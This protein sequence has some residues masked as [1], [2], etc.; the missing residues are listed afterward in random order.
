MGRSKRI[1]SE[2]TFFEDTLEIW[3]ILMKK[4]QFVKPYPNVDGGWVRDELLPKF[5]TNN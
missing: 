4:P 2:Y 5:V 1:Q 3:C